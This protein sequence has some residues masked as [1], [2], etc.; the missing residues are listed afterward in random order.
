MAGEQNSSMKRSVMLVVAAIALL[1]MIF[2]VKNDALA[3]AVSSRE[4]E[5]HFDTSTPT[6]TTD[7]TDKTSEPEVRTV[8][9]E[10]TVQVAQPIPSVTVRDEVKPNPSSDESGDDEQPTDIGEPATPDPQPT[11]DDRKKKVEYYDELYLIDDGWIN[12]PEDPTD[13]ITPIIEPDDPE[14][15][16]DPEAPEPGDDGPTPTPQPNED[17]DT[18]VTDEP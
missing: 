8:I 5:L 13:P 11:Q 9:I 2:L 6:E 3:K 12:P 16:T 10:K 18:G 14:E 17:P 15:P 7:D 1:G 4:S